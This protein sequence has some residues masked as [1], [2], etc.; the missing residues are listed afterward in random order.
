MRSWP[1]VALPPVVGEP[2]PL[3]LFDTGSG[4]LEKT[5]AKAPVTMYVC[6]ITPYDATHI[7]HAATYTAFDVIYRNLREAGS[8]VTYAQN[9]TDVDDPLLERANATG[10]DWRE[11]A[12]DQTNLFRHDMTELR[13][14]PPTDFV[15]VTDT[16]P[17]IVQRI[18]K[19]VAAGA[20]YQVGTDWYFDVSSDP[21]YGAV[22]QLDL[23]EQLALFAERGGD[24][25]RPGKRHPLDSL[26]WRGERAGEP[27]WPSELGA[28]R[29]GWHIECVAIAV[30]RL[31]DTIDIQGGGSDLA[32]PHHEM[33]A[34]HAQVLTGKR[35]FAHAY[36]HA[37]LVSYQGA[38]MSKSRGNLVFVS[39]LLAAGVDPMAIRLALLTHHYRQEW[40]WTDELLRDSTRR[41]ESLRWAVAQ[42]TGPQA[43]ETVARIRLALSNDLDCP[44]ALAAL[45]DWVAAQREFSGDSET[46]PGVL[47]RAV[48]TLLGLTL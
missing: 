40:E 47:S 18:Q 39:Q 15:A 31:G 33:S 29:P 14:L 36:V 24:P 42:P 13:I 22:S 37:G 11:L 21:N 1:T 28:G 46:A 8:A 12:I 9:V 20:A 48:D 16:I 2:L 6:G 27:S 45:D 23:E 3:Q 26:L 43:D 32:F 17:E 10:V 5:S 25:D 44:S 35:P 7:G 30:D 19:L 4:K 41:L 38:K 34:S